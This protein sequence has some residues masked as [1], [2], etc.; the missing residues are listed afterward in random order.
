[1]SISEIFIRRPVATVLISIAILL[2][3]VVGFKLL[4]QSTMPNIDLPTIQVTAALPGASPETMASS[5]ATPLEKEFSAISGLDSMNSTSSTGMTQ[6][7]LQFNLSRKIDAAAQDVQA[8]ISIASYQL[9]SDMPAPPSYQKINPAIQPILFLNVTSET[10]PLSRVNYYASKY[11][12]QRLSMVDGVAQVQVYGAQKYAVRIQLDPEKLAAHSVGMDEV[13]AAIKAGNVN[14]PTGVLNGSARTFTVESNGQLENADAYRNLIIAY[15]NESPLRLG[16]V[17]QVIDSVE[18]IRTAAW[19]NNDQRALVLAIQRQPGTNTVAVVDRVRKLLPELQAQLPASIKLEIF[20]DMSQSIRESVREVKFTLLI[21][22][23]LVI[24]V[25]FLFLRNVPATVIPGAALAMSIIG[26]FAVMYFSGFSLNILSLMALS[27]CTGFVVDDAIVMLENIV[28]HVEHK[29]EPYQAALN[30]SKEIGFTIIAMTLSLVVVFVPV[31]FM[32]GVLGRI[33]KEFAVTISAAILISGF[34]SLFLTPMLCSRFLRVHPVGE[35]HNRFYNYLENGLAWLRLGYEKSLRKVME[36]RLV[37]IVIGFVV[38]IA[39]GF[40]FARIPKG[41]IPNEDWNVLLTQTEAVQGISFDSMAA[42]QR[43]VA[44]VI[45]RNSNVEMIMHVVG[46]MGTANTGFMFVR[47]KPRVERTLD[48]DGVIESLRGE[49]SGIPG[50]KVFMQN[51]PAIPIG[52][53]EMKSPYQFTLQSPNTAELYRYTEILEEKMKGIEGIQDVSSDLQMQNPQVKVEID[54]DKASALGISSYQIE[55]LLFS[56][57]GSRKVS[58]IFM[59]E[60]QYNVILE[61]QDQYQRDPSALSKLY[62]HSNT[63]AL[64]P[65]SAVVKTGQSVGPVSIN[66]QGQLPSATIAFGLKPGISLGGA[67][68]AVKKMAIETLPTSINGNFQGT[69]QVFQSSAKGFLWLF[70]GA[71]LIIYIVLGILYE[72]FIHPITILSGLPSAAFGALLALLIFRMEL[73]I[74]AIVGIL[75]LIGI[76]K[77]NAIMMIDFAVQGMRNEGKSGKEAILDGCLIRFRPIIM[78]ST[79]AF[80]GSLPI[81]IG[82]GA[83]AAGRRPLGLA[84]AGGLLF[85]QILT[86]YLT[87]V[88]F[89]Y[90]EDF[91]KWLKRFSR[92]KN[93]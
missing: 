19:L 3:G 73:N 48:A 27:L 55:D 8:A 82:L 14:L 54:R 56:A 59:P 10:M 51:P 80:I 25:I 33:F 7:T 69:A 66:H 42:H 37:T 86:L 30:G 16:E 29:E 9:P 78:T 22:M 79:A 32:G 2:A 36:Y 24:M 4:P 89:T 28:R 90:M 67:S 77:K 64:I 88:F 23:L 41:F 38:L 87:P 52:A 47:L 31:L 65:L 46:F 57:Y 83:H 1:M 91:K 5:V 34:I 81:A 12:S 49:I 44:E 53:H 43:A 84:V 61:L 50:I 62:L 15:R 71:I 76:V 40:L 70:L 21:T 26:T 35:K 93:L 74:Y 92:H 72:D 11:I 63:G 75:M 17:A 6:I 45:G 60:D 20:F 58:T 85:S 13:V 68:A 39:T 18:E